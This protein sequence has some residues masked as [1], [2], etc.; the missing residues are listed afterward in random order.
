MLD[1]FISYPDFDFDFVQSNSQQHTKFLFRILILDE[2]TSALESSKEARVQRLLLE[3]LNLTTI[4]TVAH[5][6]ANITE[7][8]R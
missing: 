4:I 3:V 8:D 1:A 6:L 7:Y 2:A 5:R